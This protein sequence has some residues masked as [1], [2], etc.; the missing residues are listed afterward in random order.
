MIER[1]NFC[2]KM[3][4]IV[5]IKCFFFLKSILEKCQILISWYQCENSHNVFKFNSNNQQHYSYL[6]HLCELCDECFWTQKSLLSD[7][8]LVMRGNGNIV[9]IS[10]VNSF[11]K[12][13]KFSILEFSCPKGS[14]EILYCFTFI[15]IL[16]MPCLWKSIVS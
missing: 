14:V 3:A 12:V 5:A 2:A 8:E 4:V 10:A 16:K 7:I 11:L 9:V 1:G 6:G 13:R 15:L